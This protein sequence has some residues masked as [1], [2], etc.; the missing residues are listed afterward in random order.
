MLKGKISKSF[1]DTVIFDRA[2]FELPDTGFFVLGG[3][4]G[5][6]K[7]TLLRCLAGLSPFEGSLFSNKRRIGK[8]N[9]SRA[10]F[11]ARE[12]CFIDDSYVF[13]DELTVGQNLDNGAR[14]FKDRRLG[15]AEA[16]TAVRLKGKIDE[17]FKE[18]SE[19][20]KKLV[21]LAL[22][23]MRKA[24]VYLFDEPTAM[25]DRD[26]IALTVGLLEELAASSL[27]LMA[28]NDPDLIPDS[29]R[30]ALSGSSCY[31]CR[32]S[33]AEKSLNFE[34]INLKSPPR[35][36]KTNRRRSL[37]TGAFITSFCLSLAA[38]VSYLSPLTKIVRPPYEEY[39]LTDP[40]LTSLEMDSL[41][42]RERERL[43]LTED[44]WPNIDLR[45]D[46]ASRPFSSFSIEVGS[47][48]PETEIKEKYLVY[49][50]L[51]EQCFK[52][53]RG[54]YDSIADSEAVRLVGIE[55]FFDDVRIGRLKYGGTVDSPYMTLYLPKTFAVNLYGYTQG[56]VT[57]SGLA[58]PGFSRDGSEVVSLE[59]DEC[60]LP[61]S[62][63]SSTTETIKLCGQIF[64]VAG[65]HY[66]GK[67]IVISEETRLQKR[68]LLVN[69]SLTAVSEREAEGI[70]TDRAEEEKSVYLKRLKADNFEPIAVSLSIFA[71][72]LG[73]SAV[74]T[75]LQAV[76]ER[77]GLRRAHISGQTRIFLTVKWLPLW[78][79]LVFGGLFALL[80]MSVFA[81]LTFWSLAVLAAAL[82]VVLTV[83]LGAVSRGTS[84]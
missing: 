10:R 39:K 49:P 46:F 9:A 58:V 22:A 30:M 47:L 53:S 43:F 65:Y 29:A 64:K 3:P 60:L 40:G 14:L 52:L 84:L 42:Y 78:L 72:A 71:I 36:R 68:D 81:G 23:L 19:G 51:D 76:S 5:N 11:R 8:S 31:I 32:R 6:G 62:N 33:I 74:L 50:Q 27:V 41:T 4:N 37:L 35:T 75:I 54:L 16:L 70:W 38:A 1:K 13:D 77:D 26:N 73:I 7:S 63:N 56:I 17:K 59:P 12:L 83:R 2:V 66:Y 18:L 21:R 57:L 55:S 34:T 45:F 80:A 69:N 25:M 15:S 24:S 48:L 20:Q 44:W 79:S 28:T 67:N 82:A 61:F